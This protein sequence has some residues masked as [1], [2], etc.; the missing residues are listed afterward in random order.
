[1]LTQK[2]ELSLNDE[3]VHVFRQACID[4]KPR[5]AWKEAYISVVWL[6]Y[7][8]RHIGS[9]LK[10]GQGFLSRAGFR[11]R[12]SPASGLSLS[13]YFGPITDLHTKF[14]ATTNTFVDSCCWRNRA[15]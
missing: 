9:E 14:F 15:D 6:S 12:F 2:S 1:V 8:L 4:N 13:K 10:V 7:S 5:S 11:A 3:D